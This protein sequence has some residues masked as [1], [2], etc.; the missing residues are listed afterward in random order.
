M[1]E[2]DF[3]NC[4]VRIFNTNQQIMNTIGAELHKRPA[5]SL[6]MQQF[7]FLHTIKENPGSSL[8]A[9]AERMGMI[10][11]SASKLVDYLVQQ[12]YV[13]RETDSNDRRKITI[14]ITQIGLDAAAATNNAALST[15]IEAVS[16]LSASE[17]AVINLAMEMIERAF[18]QQR[19]RKP[20][21][22]ET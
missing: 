17:C 9:L 19:N 3:R 11:S 20:T 22:E 16:E 6:S 10:L 18:T 12:N 15:V 21:T 7:M 14:G 4:A 1:P 5:N 13:I 8:S 2:Q